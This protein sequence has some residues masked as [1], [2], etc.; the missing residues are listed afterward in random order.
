LG[1]FEDRLLTRSVDLVVPHAKFLDH[2]ARVAPHTPKLIYSN[3]SNLYED[4]LID[5]LRYADAHGLSR[6]AAF[7]HVAKPTPFSGE[8]PSSQPV[9]WFWA[10]YRLGP[11]GALADLSRDARG[12]NPRGFSLGR[13][14]ESVYIGY[15]EKFR[16]INVD[17]AYVGRRWSYQLEYAQD[18]GVHGQP[19]RLA[20]LDVV[21]DTTEG[22]SR[23]GRIT[24]DP[25]ADW[26]AAALRGSPR[27]F[28]IRI[29]ATASGTPPAVR[30]ILGRDYVGAGGKTEGTMPAFDARADL[31][32][33]GYLNDAEFRRRDPEKE[34]RFVYE[35][36]MFAAS[37]GQMR[38]GT[39]AANADFRRWA[40]DNQRRRLAEHP[41]AD[42]LF[43]DNSMG[44]P[45]VRA[46]AALE[47]TNGH[48]E[49]YAS[50]MREID[51]A[52]SPR[53][54]LPNTCGG[55]RGSAEPV[56]RES[57]IYFE[58]FLIR[59][60]S[61][62]Y[63]RFEDAANLVAKRSSLSSPPPYAVLDS[64]P[65][66][67]SPTDPRTQLATLAYYY[68]LADPD[69]TFLMFY[70][71]FEP[72]SPWVRHWSKAAACDVG[73]PMA[74]WSVF[75]SG[76]DPSNPRA[77]Y[78]IYQRP[79][80]KALVLYKPLSFENWNARASIGNDTA[81]THPLD[82]PHRPLQS[83]G[84]LGGPISKVLLRNGEGAVL[85][86]TSPS[87]ETGRPDRAGAD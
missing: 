44:W 27:L 58:E 76:V 70:G 50:L 26:S 6:E 55:Y 48:G 66:G 79:Y 11:G 18:Q 67:G 43:M 32:R 87:D 23:A 12:G 82:G 40:V 2:I 1:P 59:P 65:D 86:R 19:P 47:D 21:E 73:R 4:L 78:R 3:V 61:H 72:G 69:R 85:V 36:R 49:H 37:Y 75:G 80:Q 52:I 34:A 5:W 22:F 53:W 24:F 14:G 71:G 30:S 41:Q 64:R 45:M 84:Q 51:E 33:D 63:H 7:F 83:S 46:V 42:G 13:T 10:V 60:L 35:S 20:H 81:T 17:L 68:L 56:A 39:N 25:P 77:Q 74:R 15:P 31:D 38:F 29:R 9:T 28:F 16:E 62:N 57:A 54:V 8:S